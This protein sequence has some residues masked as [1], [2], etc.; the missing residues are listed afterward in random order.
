[1]WSLALNVTK[2]GSER[3]EKGKQGFEAGFQFIGNTS[4]N[5]NIN[6]LNAARNTFELMEKVNSKYSLSS[7]Y[8]RRINTLENSMQNIFEI[9]LNQRYTNN[10]K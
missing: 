3:L 4:V 1:M 9:N 8:I 6:N 2:S 7:K 10:L 5:R